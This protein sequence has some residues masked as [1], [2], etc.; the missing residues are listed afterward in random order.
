MLHPNPH[1]T[2]KAERENWKM[3]MTSE[4]MERYLKTHHL[5]DST[6]R[7]EKNTGVVQ[8]INACE[9]DFSCHTQIRM[10]H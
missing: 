7:N 3:L 8:A 1:A 5:N 2:L 10:L 6:G 4:Y 9:G